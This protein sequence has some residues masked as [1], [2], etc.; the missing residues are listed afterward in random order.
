[1]TVVAYKDGTIAADS[2]VGSSNHYAGNVGKIARNSSGDLIGASGLTAWCSPV[3]RWFASGE[4]GKMPRH[5]P[6]DDQQSASAIIIRRASPGRVYFVECDSA[7]APYPIEVDPACGFA[8]G[9]G[10]EVARG[11]M[12]AGASA[13]D[14][15]KAAIHLEDGCGGDIHAMRFRGG[16]VILTAASGYKG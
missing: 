5:T 6:K 3:L 11:A 10:R 4:R 7:L 13:I 2:M 15:V 8:I 16:P 12:Y 14:A 9:C 1:M